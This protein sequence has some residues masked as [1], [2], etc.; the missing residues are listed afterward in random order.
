[1]DQEATGRYEMYTNEYIQTNGVTESWCLTFQLHA[2]E[3]KVT[4][5]KRF[6]LTTVK[7]LFF[8]DEKLGGGPIKSL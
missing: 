4:L 6:S 3:S 5:G 7:L 8:E 2:Y 1:M